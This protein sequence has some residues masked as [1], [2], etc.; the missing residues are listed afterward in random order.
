[1][2]INT[3]YHPLD[4]PK[5]LGPLMVD[6][7]VEASACHFVQENAMT[8]TNTDAARRRNPNRRGSAPP[9]GCQRDVLGH[10]VLCYWT[11]KLS[12]TMKRFGDVTINVFVVAIMAVVT[13]SSSAAQHSDSPSA[14]IDCAIP[15][16]CQRH[17][18]LLR[19]A[20]PR[21]KLNI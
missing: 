21:N 16:I 19:V 4:W 6:G 7:R 20:S 5:I 3:S 17:S 12:T 15:Q 1:M 13:N 8:R 11:E 10:L 2:L 9:V 14:T 18:C